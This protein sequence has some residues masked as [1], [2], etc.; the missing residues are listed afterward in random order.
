M[1]GVTHV[2]GSTTMRKVNQMAT[3]IV[4]ANSTIAKAVTAKLLHQG[5]VPIILISRSRVGDAAN[6]N[7][8][9]WLCDY[10]EAQIVASCRRLQEDALLPSRIIIFNGLLHQHDV[11]PEKRLADVTTENWLQVMQVNA[12]LPLLWVKSLASILPMNHPATVTIFSARVGSISDN[13][14][15][16]WYSY[17]SSKAALN[18]LMKSAS[19]ELK[20]THPKLALMLF[21]PGTTDTPLSKPFQKNVP[22]DKLFTPDFVAERLLAVS[23]QH[24]VPGELSF[25]DWAGE[26]I[27]F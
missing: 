27:D 18:M 5:S 23:E 21:H 17:R 1:Y 2:E 20:R 14:T 8:R 3:L 15:G 6:T 22:A 7:L 16:G 11:T 24:A 10:T 12:L 19:L 13:R 4:G 9:A 25:I 26:P